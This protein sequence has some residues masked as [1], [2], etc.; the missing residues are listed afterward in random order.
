MSLA[1]FAL[2]EGAREA[3]DRYLQHHYACSDTSRA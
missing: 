3:A 1:Y 2:R